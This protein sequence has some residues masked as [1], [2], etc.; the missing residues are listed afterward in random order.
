VL[1]EAQLGELGGGCLCIK[2][3]SKRSGVDDRGLF[4]LIN[5]EDQSRKVALPQ[6]ESNQT[7]A[8]TKDRWWTRLLDTSL[9]SSFAREA[10]LTRGWFELEA[11]TLVVIEE[12]L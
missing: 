8:A 7:P 6:I 11:N 10:L 2:M 12:R 3:A 5:N 1:T 4:I 9:E